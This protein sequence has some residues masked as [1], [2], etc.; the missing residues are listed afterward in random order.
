MAFTRRAFALMISLVL[1]TS[2]RAWAEAPPSVADGAEAPGARAGTASV[3]AQASAPRSGPVVSGRPHVVQVP[4]PDESAQSLLTQDRTA[5]PSRFAPRAKPIPTFPTPYPAPA[6]GLGPRAERYWI[7]RWA[8]DWSFLKGAPKSQK[9]DLFDPLKYIDIAGDGEV[10]LTLSGENR[11]R[12]NY[13]TQPGLRA[14]K[15]QDQELFRNIVGADLH[16]GQHFRA[17][18]EINSS[19]V[20]GHN[21]LTVSTQQRNDAVLEQ[22][23]AEVRGEAFGTS[24]SVRGG[25]Q[26]FSDGPPNIIHIRPAPDVYTSVNGVSANLAWKN[27]RIDLFSF[28]TLTLRDGAFDDPINHGERFQGFNS[29]LRVPAFKTGIGEGRLFLDPFFFHYHNDVKRYG[30]TT[31]V[32]RRDFYGARLWGTLGDGTLDTT[33][34]RQTGSFADRPISSW[35]VFSNFGYLLNN[36]SLHPRLGIHMD[37]TGGGGAYGRGTL[38]DFNFFYGS[39]PYFTWGNLFGP[40]NIQDVA[41]SFRFTPL[42]WMTVTTELEILRRTSQDDAIY[43]FTGTPYAGTQ[44][45]RGHDVGKL[46]RADAAIFIN[47]H[48]TAAV[49]VEH[50][51]AGNVFKR[52]GYTSTTFVGPELYFRW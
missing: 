19:Q 14:A 32:E 42:N 8:E 25:T 24:V 22:A 37:Y 4:L 43:T 34:V 1:G 27:A 20:T 50:L 41:P 15:A 21:E 9:R 28:R 17:F 5:K 51:F 18:A 45:V 23:F 31:G 16:L 36:S 29:S 47:N 3:A 48:F 10:Y 30:T 38:H 44:I 11:F 33:L 26:E 35:A 13:T 40:S 39:I 52:A 49:K 2:T 6:L 12:T 7:Q 46:W